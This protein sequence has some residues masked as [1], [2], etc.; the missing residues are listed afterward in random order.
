[1]PSIDPYKRVKLEDLPESSELGGLH[2]RVLAQR[3]RLGAITNQLDIWRVELRETQEWLKRA[4]Y[5]ATEPLEY[6]A[7][8][9]KAELLEASIRELEP[10]AAWEG[11]DL[12]AVESNLVEAVERYGQLFD[13]LHSRS[14]LPETKEKVAKDV[15]RMI[16]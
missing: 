3:D 6:A 14:L 9:A 5:E 8:K 13:W 10:R 1:M 2:R 12:L 7:R 4:R 16:S 11:Q 15:L